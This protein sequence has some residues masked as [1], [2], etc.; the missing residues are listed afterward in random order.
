MDRQVAPAKTKA[1]AKQPY[2]SG[3]LMCH[4]SL[5]GIA[6]FLASAY[7]AWISFGHVLH[8]EY[9]WPHDVWT[10]GT[11]IVWIVLLAALTF[12]T[13][14]LRERIF[15]GVL[16]LNFLAAFGLTLWRSVPLAVVR[17]ARL[18]T[19]MLWALAALVSL[20]T[21]ARA[22]SVRAEGKQE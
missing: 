19:G 3:H 17:Q 7:F 12:D 2:R 9:D 22:R 18:G 15:F 4:A 6:G 16:V 11:Y 10:A 13:R 14:C 8:N 1:A 5:W 20:T 21:M